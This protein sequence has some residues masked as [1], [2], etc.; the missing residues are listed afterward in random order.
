MPKKTTKKVTKKVVKK[1]EV[2]E[3]PVVDP[4]CRKCRKVLGEGFLVVADGRACSPACA[5]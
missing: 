5:N 3:T 2:E 1:V 4:R